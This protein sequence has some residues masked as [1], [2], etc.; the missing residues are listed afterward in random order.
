MK[1]EWHRR[2]GDALG[3]SQ[4]RP[5]G[6]SLQRA[7]ARAARF[8]LAVFR[9]KP[10]K[11]HLYQDAG[12]V[13]VSGFALA[14]ANYP[15]ALWLGGQAVPAR[16]IL[17]G[18]AFLA[19]GTLCALLSVNWGGVLM[20]AWCCVAIRWVVAGFLMHSAVAYALAL[21]SVAIGIAWQRTK[22]NVTDYS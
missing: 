15:V 9:T 13:V 1:W 4:E 21:L 14:I 20:A 10:E 16:A 19:G 7:Y 12:L 18:L 11:L 17:V 22:P 6:N 3:R 2:S 8:V 5:Q